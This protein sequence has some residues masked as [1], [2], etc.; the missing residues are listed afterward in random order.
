M[1][2]REKADPL[3]LR[4]GA[5]IKHLREEQGLTQEALAWESAIQSK[6]HLSNIEAGLV[7]PTLH[8]IKHLADRLGVL[9]LDLICFPEDDPRQELIDRTRDAAPG[10]VR[11]LLTQV[12]RKGR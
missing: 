11:K 12:R 6:G 2:R 8:T 9:P 3:S 10:M 4:V 1:P 5:R 7:R